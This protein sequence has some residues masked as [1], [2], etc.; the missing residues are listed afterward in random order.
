MPFLVSQ[1]ARIHYQITGPEQGQAIVLVMGLGWDMTGW[2]G[3]LSY[4]EQY[5]V[6]R[7]DNRGAGLSDAPDQPYSILMM[8]RDVIAAMDAVGFERA[9]IYGASLGSMIAQEIALSFPDRVVS[10]VL[11]CPSPGVVSVPGSIGLLRVLA[12]RTRVSR[13]RALAMA[14]PYLVHR[15]S[16]IAVLEEWERTRIPSTPVGYKRQLRAVLRWT[17]VTRLK[18]LRVPTLIVHGDRDRLLPSANGRLIARLI[19]GARLH[20]I[21]ECGHVYS[22]D[23]P[24][25]AA[26]AVMG[27]LKEQAARA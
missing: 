26:G 17:S 14:A 18:R 6:L 19:P 12:T 13:E 16:S 4:L 9:H 7:I 10:L 20:M 25:E 2:D 15:A 11:G 23:A 5:R 21:P 8:A 27:F 1:G 22:A 3:M 24:A